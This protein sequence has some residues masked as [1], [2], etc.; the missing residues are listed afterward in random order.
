MTDG[1]GLLDYSSEE[2]TGLP[3]IKVIGVGGGGSNAVSRMF[4]EPIPGV[5]YIVVNTDAQALARTEVGRRLQIGAHL[6]KGLGVGGNPELGRQ[7]AEESREDL[8][9]ALQ[10]A[11]M[12][13]IA[14]GM[15]GGTGTGAA[16]IVAEIAREQGAL[17]VGVVTRPF[18]FEGTK[19]RRV[20]DE[21]IHHLRGKVDT[22]IAIPNDRL[23]ALCDQK[24]TMDSAFRIADDVLRQGVQAIAELVTVPGVINLDFADIR[25]VMSNAGQA[26]MGIGR[27]K[28]DQRAVEAVRSAINSPLLDTSIEG[29]KGVVFNVVGGTSLTLEEVRAAGDIIASMVDPDASIFFG[30][31]MDPKMDDEVRITIIATGFPGEESLIGRGERLSL[32]VQ[33]EDLDTPPFLRHQA[34]LRRR[35]HLP[36]L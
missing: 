2:L 24:V 12:V 21:G 29:A 16:P 14:A 25:A 30:M 4:K 3:R 19:R 22:L 18:S 28:G 26:W 7:A 23:L 31:V 27:G 11:E 10:G 5:E 20:A 33:G 1:Y 15:G 6:T 35:R 8:A 34:P 13:F 32:P 17:V 9:E 36:N